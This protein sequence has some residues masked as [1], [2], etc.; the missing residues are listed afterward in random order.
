[1]SRKQTIKNVAFFLGLFLVYLVLQSKFIHWPWFASDELDVTLGGKA[2]VNGYKLYGDFLSQHMPF[3][4]YVSAFFELFG[5]TSVTLQRY[6]FYAFYAVFWCVIYFRYRNLVNGK[7]LLIY[8]FI[9]TSLISTYE[10][11]PV[12]RPEHLAAIGGIILLLEFLNFYKNRELKWDNCLFLSISVILTFGT[13]FVA[14]FPMA[15]IVVAVVVLEIKWTIEGKIKGKGLVI[16]YLKKYIPLVIWCS[17]PWLILVTSYAMKGNL[18]NF[19]RGAYQINRTIYP[20]YIDGYG[21]SVRDA[22]VMIPS[23]IFGWAKDLIAFDNFDL[24]AL[25]RIIMLVSFI[26]FLGRVY[27]TKSRLIAI[28][29]YLY[30]SAMGTREVFTFHSTNL[31]AILALVF[32][33]QICDVFATYKREKKPMNLKCASAVLSLFLVMTPYW[34]DLSGFHSLG[35][36]EEKNAN[37]SILSAVLKNGEAVWLLNFDCTSA[38][39]ADRPAIQNVGATPWMWECEG[40]RCLQQMKKE[41]PRVAVFNEYHEVWGNLLRDYAPELVAFIHENY[42]FYEQSDCIY[43]RND[44]YDE[45]IQILTAQ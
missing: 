34:S 27:L 43:I 24:N 38:M 23:H 44:Y 1:M 18:G 19:I 7:A 42:T 2:I 30:V 6:C 36:D 26:L 16:Y 33:L 10:W 40:A 14:A 39:L 17:V 8:P 45:A 21:Y 13:I 25:V 9:F 28:T 22:F 3:T 15:I 11:G 32:A 4:Y 37:A 29:I 41:C 12:L 5:A 35:I 31:V 20:K